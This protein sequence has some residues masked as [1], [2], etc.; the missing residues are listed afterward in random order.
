[1]NLMNMM[2]NNGTGTGMGTESGSG[3]A[4]GSGAAQAAPKL[5]ARVRAGMGAAAVALAVGAAAAGCGSTGLSVNGSNSPSGQASATASGTYSAQLC[6]DL[7]TLG[8]DLNNLKQL[9]GSSVTLDQIKAL[10]SDVRSALDQA[11]NDADGL[12]AAKLAAINGAF[13]A[14]T[15]A[16]NAVS[17]STS[18]SQAYQSI[19]SQIF[20]LTTAYDAAKLGSNCPSLPSV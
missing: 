1:M 4:S 7:G 17:S 11:T 14:F 16:L 15:D 12:D 10:D 19:Q 3:S 8:T 5:R 13:I 2:R 6:S 9:K 20:A 18:G